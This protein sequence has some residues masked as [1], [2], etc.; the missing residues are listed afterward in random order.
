MLD[1]QYHPFTNTMSNEGKLKTKYNT[2]KQT[3][4]I[5]AIIISHDIKLAQHKL[6]TERKTERTATL[7]PHQKSFCRVAGSWFWLND[8]IITRFRQVASTKAFAR[9]VNITNFE[10]GVCHS[11]L[12]N[13]SKT[14]CSKTQAEVTP[15]YEEPI[16]AP[17]PHTLLL[18]LSPPVPPLSHEQ[19]SHHK[20]S[21]LQFRQ[22]LSMFI[23]LHGVIVQR[24]PTNREAAYKSVWAESNLNG[25]LTI[26]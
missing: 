20:M 23:Q 18:T 15:A 1:L 7:P 4:G 9:T 6:T 3:E 2:W 10:G 17:P 26:L 21:R 19:G 8:S 11:V 5:V 25:F 14:H 12:A 16:S 24:T 13:K 22:S